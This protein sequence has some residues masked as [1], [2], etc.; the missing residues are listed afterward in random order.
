MGYEIRLEKGSTKHICPAC[1][2]KTFVRYVDTKTDDY[3]A[4]EVGRC[5]REVKCGYH[6]KPGEY[7]QLSGKNPFHKRPFS[8]V[9]STK[10]IKAPDEKPV[11]VPDEMFEKS[12]QH[13][14]QNSLFLFLCELCGVNETLELCEWYCV[15]T[16]KLWP[17]ACVFWYVDQFY[18]VTR[19]KV[20]LYDKAGHRVKGCTNSTV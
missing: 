11:Y 14:E 7:F 18:R 20:M 13:Y 3:I 16:S 9:Q 12:L 6:L 1:K 5:D 2:R 8:N 15:G 4:D 10:G 17:G 19:G